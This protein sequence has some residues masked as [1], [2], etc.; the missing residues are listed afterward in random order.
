VQ[1]LE[2]VQP[3][4]RLDVTD[5]AGQHFNDAFVSTESDRMGSSSSRL[6]YQALLVTVGVGFHVGFWSG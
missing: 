6:L 1:T 4:L 5:G 3:R 2:K